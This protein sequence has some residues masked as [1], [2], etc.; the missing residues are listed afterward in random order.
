MIVLLGRREASDV[1]TRV[2]DFMAGLLCYYAGTSTMRALS[3]SAGISQKT[4]DADK[5][6]D[7]LIHESDLALYAAKKAG[8]A[9]CRIYTPEMEHEHEAPSAQN[10]YLVDYENV[11]SSGLDGIHKLG[12]DSRVCIFYSRNASHMTSELNMGIKESQA[13]ITYHHAETGAKNAL[14]FQLSSYLGEI[15]AENVGKPCR[16]YIVSKDGGF[17]ALIP[18]WR[19]NGAEV[20]IIPDISGHAT[21]ELE[22]L[23]RRIE[24][25]TGDALMAGQIAEII[26][27]CATK[28]EVNTAIQRLFRNDKAGEI[29][30]SIRPLIEDKPGQH[31]RH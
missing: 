31:K 25:L 27:K 21:A 24:V 10:F 15:I 2:N 18:F 29:Y 1:E 6:I 11:H 19:E 7:R 26:T 3:V 30:R 16:Y 5:S 4:P 23:A 13:E 12:A 22:E 28:V 14:D 17:S 8:R 9:C 20:S